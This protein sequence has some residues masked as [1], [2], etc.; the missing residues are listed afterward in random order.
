MKKKVMKILTIHF[1]NSKNY[2]YLQP[3][4]EKFLLSSVG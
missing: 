1:L 4:I 3:R 2:I